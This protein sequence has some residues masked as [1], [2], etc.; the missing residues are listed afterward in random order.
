MQVSP[1]ELP[2]TDPRSQELPSEINSNTKRSMEFI[3]TLVSKLG[4]S[5]N[6]PEEEVIK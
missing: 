5:L 4:T 2:V 1:G 3:P 6:V